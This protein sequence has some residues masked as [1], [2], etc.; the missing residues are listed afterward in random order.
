[1]QVE[2]PPA[3]PTAQ[4]HGV[5]QYVHLSNRDRACMFDDASAEYCRWFLMGR[6][7]GIVRSV[8]HNRNPRDDLIDCHMMR[9]PA[10]AACKDQLVL[11]FKPLKGEAER[12]HGETLLDEGPAA[13]HLCHERSLSAV[14]NETAGEPPAFV[15]P[16]GSGMAKWWPPSSRDVANLST[17]GYLRNTGSANV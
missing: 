11:I 15:L 17:N 10:G 12:M 6:P 4:S 8:H 9:H 16:N 5:L 3:L 7:D 13:K 14:Y 1:M 2:D